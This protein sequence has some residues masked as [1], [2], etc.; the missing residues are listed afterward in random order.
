M[1]QDKLFNHQWSPEQIQH[2]LAHEDSQIQI[3]YA[4]IYRGLYKGLF[5]VDGKLATR[6]LRHKGKTRHTKTYEEKRG[7]I[8]ITHHLKDRPQ[9]ANERLRIGDWEADTV[10]GKSGKACLVTLVD[11]CSR[12]LICTTVKAKKAT[13][14]SQAIIHA[15]A[16]QPVFTITPDRRK[17]ICQTQTSNE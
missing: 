3:S 12:F 16:N 9:I 13:L 6:K 5:D 10:L 8:A 14:V 1:V 15:L 11:R 17:R 7:K 2:R 4:T